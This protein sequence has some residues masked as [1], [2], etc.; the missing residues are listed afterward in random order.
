VSTAAESAATL[1]T[2]IVSTANESLATSCFD[3]PHAANTNP[4][5]INANANNFFILLLFKVINYNYTN[6]Q[7]KYQK[8]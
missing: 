5:A 8:S 2:A 1:S 3:S 4:D 6:I 7:K